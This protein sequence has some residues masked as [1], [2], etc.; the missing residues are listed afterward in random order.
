M[1]ARRGTVT[2]G[3][4][5]GSGPERLGPER[6]GP[7]RTGRNGAVS[8]QQVSWGELGCPR[9]IGLY[10]GG[11]GQIRVKRIHIIVA[12]NDPAAMFT[13]VAFRPPLGPPEFQ[14]G[15]RVA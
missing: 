5:L 2:Q 6:L 14:L 12:E 10:R 4:G 8:A 15:H 9:E 7:E 11:G 13:V 1:D 3:G